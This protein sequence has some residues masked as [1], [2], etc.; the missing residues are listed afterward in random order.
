MLYLTE[1]DVRQLLT[2]DAAIPLVEAAFRKL[3]LDEAVNAPRQRVQT[4]AVM[5][6]VLP[7]AAK[8]LN[9][10]G[11]KAYTTG[12]FE[13]QFH[14]YLFDPKLGGLNAIIEADYLGQ[15]RTGAASAV[16]CQ[17]NS[18]HDFQGQFGQSRFHERQI[19][20][21]TVNRSNFLGISLHG[22]RRRV[23]DTRDIQPIL[24]RP[25]LSLLNLFD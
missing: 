25:L 7:A 22:S 5:L 15:V 2:M 4:D 14:V 12:K 17:G 20:K 21:F 18:A 8:T 9:A 13:A 1:S 3:A 16:A 24:A 19:P 10:L 23:G 11:F 6:H